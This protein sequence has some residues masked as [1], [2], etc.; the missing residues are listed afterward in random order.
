MVLLQLLLLLL[1]L[2]GPWI[3]L[4]GEQISGWLNWGT[5]M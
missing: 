4:E 1:L 2:L 3:L 5:D